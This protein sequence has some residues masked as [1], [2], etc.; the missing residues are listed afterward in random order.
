MTCFRKLKRFTAS[1]TA[2]RRG[3]VR[4]VCATRVAWRDFNATS[5]LSQRSLGHIV[6]VQAMPWTSPPD[7]TR[8]HPGGGRWSRTLGRWISIHRPFFRCR[9]EASRKAQPGRAG[10]FQRAASTRT[11]ALNSATAIG[12]DQARHGRLRRP[13][14]PIGDAPKAS[15]RVSNSGDDAGPSSPPA[16]LTEPGGGHLPLSASQLPDEMPAYGQGS[17]EHIQGDGFGL[18]D[19]RAARSHRGAWRPDRKG[20]GPVVRVRCGPN[21]RAGRRVGGRRVWPGRGEGT[22]CGL[23]FPFGASRREVPGRA[24]LPDVRR[25]MPGLHRGTGVWPGRRHASVRVDSRRRSGHSRG[26]RSVTTTRVDA[27]AFVALPKSVS[28]KGPREGK[29][30]A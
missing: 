27:P 28:A 19:S 9:R 7:G 13:A 16:R 30:V 15:Q 14:T 29:A 4:G 23:T 2:T 10:Q 17:W 21:H 11:T 5:T 24:R 12:T 3:K 22:G 20:G 8:R 25:R 18:V 26:D 1:G 6:C